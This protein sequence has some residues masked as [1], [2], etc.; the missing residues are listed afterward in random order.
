M[1]DNIQ[2]NCPKITRIESKLP[3]FARTQFMKIQQNDPK[4]IK[5]S[6]IA[7]T[8]STELVGSL[9]KLREPT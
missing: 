7:R 4:L 1:Q 2:E 3:K 6:N 8:Q 9:S 5:L